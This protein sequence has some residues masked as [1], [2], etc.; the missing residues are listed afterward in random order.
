M[1]QTNINDEI[2]QV[3]LLTK[4]NIRIQEFLKDSKKDLQNFQLYTVARLTAAFSLVDIFLQFL[5]R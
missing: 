2:N 4:Q 3:M 5:S 1:F